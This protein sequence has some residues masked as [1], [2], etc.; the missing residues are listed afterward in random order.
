[1]GLFAAI[2][3]DGLG[4][5]QIRAYWSQ[6]VNLGASQ[7]NVPDSGGAGIL[8]LFVSFGYINNKNITKVELYIY[9]AII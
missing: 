2:K 1:M 6:T 7:G 5:E 8:L 9:V 3:R 4:E